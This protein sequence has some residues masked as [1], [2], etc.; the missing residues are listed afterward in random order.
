MSLRAD[1]TTGL[2]IEDGKEIQSHLFYLLAATAIVAAALLRYADS[3]PHLSFYFLAISLFGVPHGALDTLVARDKFRLTSFKRWLTFG[4]VYLGLASLVL[5]LWSLTPSTALMLFL[6]ISVLHFSSD[7]EP[8]TFLGTK[9]LYG[10]SIVVLPALFHFT[11]I[12]FLFGLL[13]GSDA[14][15][16]LAGL[17]KTIAPFWSIALAVVI[18]AE[19]RKSHWSS[20]LDLFFVGVLAAA[21]PPLLSFTIFFVIQHSPRHVLQTLPDLQIKNFKS[22]SLMIALP[23]VLVFVVASIAYMSAGE[24]S[25][26][27]K[28][29]KIL[30]IGLSALTVPHL[31]L[32]ERKATT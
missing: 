9:L 24:V 30:F 8:A 5:A 23:L 22:L 31:L 4:S 13:V 12:Q 32:I 21:S 28:L 29:A 20:A 26:D 19:I 14:G 16:A 27:S 15:S 11:E 1:Q 10:G 25:V 17:L 2:S 7:L 3:R 18:I 6:L